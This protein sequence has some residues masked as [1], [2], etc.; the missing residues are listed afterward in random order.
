MRF[1]RN[2]CELCTNLFNSF[3]AFCDGQSNT[4]LHK[5][6]RICNRSLY[7]Q[8]SETDIASGPGSDRAADQT[9][10]SGSKKDSEKPE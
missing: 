6:L 1:V 3:S 8:T 9:K 2:L 10:K 4:V 5:H 7:L